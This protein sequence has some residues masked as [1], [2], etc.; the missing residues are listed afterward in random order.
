MTL[1]AESHEVADYILALA[2][3]LDV[4]DV[5]STLSA[6]LARHEVINA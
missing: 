4:M 5:Y 1:T 3:P 2:T 6:Y